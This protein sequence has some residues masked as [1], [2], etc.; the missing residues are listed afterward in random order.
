MTQLRISCKNLGKLALDYCPRC[1]WLEIK[2]GYKL[3]FQIFPGIFSSL[4]SYQKKIV[5]GFFDKYGY[6]P[7]WFGALAHLGTPIP[8]PH[9]SKFRY[10]DKERDI[11][12]T[13]MPDEILCLPNGWLRILDYKT[14]KYTE[15]QDSLLPM[16]VVQLNSYSVVA[17]ALNMGKVIGLSL[18]YF[19]PPSTVS[20]EDA[21]DLTKK[22]GFAM[23]FTAKVVQIEL[24]P[25]MIPPLLRKA[26][27][28]F[29]AL[30]APKGKAGCRD[31]QLVERT[32]NLLS[33]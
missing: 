27:E 21:H 7:P 12:L 13:G 1:V 3:P 5:H 23:N 4:D 17:E 11:L 33:A 9:H 29:D 26:R 25:T 20:P 32:T 10:H 24:N 18:V 2:T 22:E 16:Y 8:V 31:C 28:I 15:G 6:L 14:A 19:E 30:E